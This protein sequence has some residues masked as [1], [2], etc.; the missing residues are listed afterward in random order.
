MM[1]LLRA[2]A[3]LIVMAAAS[4]QQPE[5]K[6]ETIVVTGVY[7]PIAIDEVDRSVR[8]L[9]VQG[10]ELLSNTLVDF[11]RLDPSIDIRERAPNGLQAD[12]SIRGGTFGQTLVLVD[13]QRS[14]EHTSEL[15]SQ[16]NLVCRLL[17]EKKKRKGTTVH[18]KST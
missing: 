18:A 16:S 7:E 3:A 4:A 13:G 11:L 5:P 15:Q 9:P 10:E 1:F 12:I 17:L 8:V 6:H 14:E 2:M